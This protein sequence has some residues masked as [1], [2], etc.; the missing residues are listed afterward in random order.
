MQDITTAPEQAT[1]STSAWH[2]PTLTIL[3]TGDAESSATNVGSDSG[4]YS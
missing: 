2:E 3:D 1:E 4:I